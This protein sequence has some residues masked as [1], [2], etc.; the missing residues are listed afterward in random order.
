MEKKPDFADHLKL[1][2]PTLSD[3]G[4][5]WTA[6]DLFA[7]CGGM[8]LGFEACGFR[9]I[10]YEMDADAEATYAKN[11]CGESHCAR[12]DTSTEF[13]V[14]PDLIIAGPPCQPFSVG[15]VQRG[16]K[17]SRDGFP[18]LLSAVERCRPPL[19]IFENVRGMLYRNMHYFEEIVSV[20]A[21]KGYQVER[22]LLNAVHYGVPQR[23]E[24][25]VCVAHRGAWQWPR[26][27]SHAP[28]SVG[29]ALGALAHRVD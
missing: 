11:L 26:R 19:V 15:G 6:L 13:D 27:I 25:L 1:E 8:A 10:G 9:T 18:I 20:L 14:Q 3:R 4:F 24:R 23:R 12:L 22:K 5:E 21:G 7:G 16:L 29:D 28:F 17:D 2:L